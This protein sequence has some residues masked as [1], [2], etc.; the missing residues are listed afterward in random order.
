MGGNGKGSTAV[1]RIGRSW[2]ES[3]RQELG[4][5]WLAQRTV[6]SWHPDRSRLRS[7]GP[8]ESVARGW[9]S[10]LWT[11]CVGSDRIRWH[12][13][14]AGS[15]QAADNLHKKSDRIGSA[16]CR[17]S[18]VSLGQKS[19]KVGRAGSSWL[20]KASTVGI[21]IGQD[22]GQAR[23]SQWQGTIRSFNGTS[24]RIGSGEQRAPVDS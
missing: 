9:L 13:Q 5:I 18:I 11:N 19:G 20:D 14:K 3:R 10:R 15:Q 2:G 23:S 8:L 22:A 21:W 24:S 1:C 6:N 4:R 16:T 12:R 17:Q 7:P